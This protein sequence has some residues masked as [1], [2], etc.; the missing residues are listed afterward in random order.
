MK[1]LCT[2]QMGS[3]TMGQVMRVMAIAKELQRRGHEVKFLAGNELISVIASLGIDVIEVADMPQQ[4][5]PFGSQLDDLRQREDML[6]RR[7]QVMGK[8]KEI[9]TETA[10]REK[11]NLLLCGT[12]TGPK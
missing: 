11:P 10:R 7:L 1:V 9:E 8:I 2:A 6:A 5:Y 4:D 12:M 3:T